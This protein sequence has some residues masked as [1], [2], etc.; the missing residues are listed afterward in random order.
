VLVAAQVAI[1]FVMLIGAGLFVRT[2]ENL[3]HIDPGFRHEGVL[4][5]SGD[6][7][8]AVTAARTAFYLDLLQRIEGLPGVVSASLASNTPLSGGWWTGPVA[9]DKQLPSGEVAHINSVAPRFFETMRTP[10]VAGRDFTA[11]DD[12]GA[13]SVAI[14]NE[15]FVRRWFQDGHS[16]GRNISA[17]DSLADM[18]IVGVVK[19]AISQSLRE[20]PPPA[21]YVP[22]FQRQTEFP[23]FVVYA[24]GSLTQV[25][26]ELRHELQSGLPN[27]AIE[28]H[29]LSA[30][31][32]AALVQERLMAAL[33]G[34][35]GALA[36]ILAAV[37]LYGLM[38]Y[39]IARRTGEFG[40]RM[41]LGAGRGDLIWL[42]VEGALRLLGTGLLLGLPAA[43]AASRLVATMLWGLTAND[44]ATIVAATALLT[45][46]G[47]L[48]G[49]LPARRAAKIDPMAALR[50]E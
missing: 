18:Q 33:A 23:T 9:I 41:A 29:T 49:W 17:G 40:V 45:L 24:S 34:A 4:L 43:W 2:F 48:A 13:P 7:H 46:T 22:L 32:D 37:G 15:A 11:R 8:R 5:V 47:L 30:Q 12:V 50:C 38:A 21:V 6:V 35:F 42:V 20:P 16:I 39:T 10:L 14:V 19:D 44:P 26:S 3:D 31:M 28:I 27:T 1:S 25:A 36:L